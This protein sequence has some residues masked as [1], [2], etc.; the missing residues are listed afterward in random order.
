MNTSTVYIIPVKNVGIAIINIDKRN[1]VNR[2]YLS[3][4]YPNSIPPTGLIK[5]A[6]ANTAN[7]SIKNNQKNV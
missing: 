1:A 3:P 6:P 5:N 7:D 4:I 2:E